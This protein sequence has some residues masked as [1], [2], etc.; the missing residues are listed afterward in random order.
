MVATY[1]SGS[2]GSEMERLRRLTALCSA[3][4]VEIHVAVN[5]CS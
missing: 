5:S 3:A 2:E 4:V 1:D